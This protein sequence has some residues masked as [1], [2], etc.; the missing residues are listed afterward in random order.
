MK[1]IKLIILVIIL[2]ITSFSCNKDDNPSPEIPD[3][4][5]NLKEQS[6]V[7]S[8][9][10]FGFDLFNKINNSEDQNKNIFISPLSVS[11]ALAM[12]YNGADNETK[13]AMEETLRLN[14]LT[15][16]EI[17]NSFKNIMNSLIG[18]DPKVAFNIANS[19]WYRDSYHVEQDFID[20]NKNYYDAEVNALDFADSQ[21]KNII[22]K[23]VADK[24]N[25]KIKEIVD[26]ISPE[27]VMYLINAIYFKGNWKYKF[28]SSDTESKPFYLA[29]G[30]TKNVLM[31]QQESSFNY[32]SNDIFEAV[33]MPYGG[34]KFSMVV[35]L[36][37]ND[38]T[39]SDII[40]ELNDDN[41]NAW[42]NGFQKL[43]NIHIIM[44][45]FKFQYEK[46]LNDVLID[47]G[48]GIA[49]SDRADFTKINPKG[50]IAISKVKHKTFVDVNEEGT[51]AAAVTSVEI[52]YTSIGPSNVFNANKPFVFAIREKSTNSIIFIGKM[53]EPDYE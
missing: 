28:D 8:S 50:G 36:P 42:L 15:T 19:I 25:N 51:E 22:N 9:N 35:L 32:L 49:F 48:L 11:F 2:S 7:N 10:K 44:P 26:N 4:I 16:D 38:K 1:T 6:L 41:W 30:T 24:T 29:D 45:K 14:G 37:K 27:T 31:M 33:E 12:T 21:A 47:M 17:N 23:W 43:D 46:K 13:T 52:S 20:V 5:L 40:N 18:L 53:A 3:I 34:E 39:T